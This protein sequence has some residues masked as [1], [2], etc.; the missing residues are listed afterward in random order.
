M[1]RAKKGIELLRDKSLNR[2]IDFSRNERDR[3]GLRGLLPHRTAT[4]K[5][6]VDRVMTNLAR[7]P[8]DIDRYMLLSGLQE[9]NERLFYRAVIDHIET[10]MPMIYT[11]TVGEACREYSHIARDPKGFFI[12]PDDRGEIE[13]ILGN[14]PENDIRVIVVTDGQRILGLGDLGANGMGIPIGKLALYTACAGIPPA[15]VPPGDARRRH[16]QRGPARRPALPRLPQAPGPGKAYVGL[17][18]EF[19]AAV[20]KRYPEALIQFEDFLTPNAYA[21]LRRTGS[22]SSASTTTSRAPPRWRSPGVYAATRITKVRFRDLRDHVPRRRLGGDRH[23]RPDGHRPGGRGPRSRGGPAPPLVRRRQRP[24]GQ[25]RGPTSWSTTGRTPTTT[26]RSTS[27]ARDRRRP[28]ARADRRH[29]RAGNLHPGG[30]RTDE[31]DQRPADDLRPVQSDVQGRV[32]R[33][34]G[35]RMERGPS[36][37]HSGSPFEPVTS[38]AGNCVPGR[39]TTPTSSRASAWAP[40]PAAPAPCPTSSSW[41]RPARWP[42]GWARPSSNRPVSIR[43]CRRSARSRSPSP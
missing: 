25:G 2:S 41:R 28:T 26:R 13:R 4:K 12:T 43:P 11:P 40:W 30:R 38:A 31:R 21:L 27:R 39:A 18:D 3:L 32:H 20:Q 7:L 17:V 42:G 16:Q 14:W 36:G 22:A 5:H 34:A 37:V 1:G 15:A 29:R 10:L 8:R 23:R 6:L 24:G 19:V 9:R 33:R 35:L